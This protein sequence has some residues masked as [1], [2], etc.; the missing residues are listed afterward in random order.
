MA[1]YETTG[2]E[3][4]EQLDGEIDYIVAGA[5]SG[6]TITG[7]L[8]YL[9]EQNSKIKGVLGDPYGS[10]IGGGIEGCYKIEGI[11]NN[12]IPKTMD[13]SYIDIVKKVKD[14]EAFYYVKELAKREG[15]VVGSS[16]G[17]AMAAAIALSKDID[18]GNIVVIF[19]DRGDRYFSK[20]IFD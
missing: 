3:I 4:Y 12:F 14:E 5:G 19:P 13:L 15:I 2:K 9:K 1:H 18:S 16:S 8:K 6:G 17:A 11:G 10:T 20:N 7:V